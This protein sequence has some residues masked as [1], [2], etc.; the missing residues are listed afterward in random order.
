MPLVWNW[1]T[2]QM[3]KCRKTLPW[4][5]VRQWRISPTGVYVAEPSH[6]R[7][8]H[9][10]RQLY[11]PCFWVFFAIWNQKILSIQIS[12]I[13]TILLSPPLLIT[14]DNLFKNLRT[15]GVGATSK[16]TEG[17]S[18]EKELLWTSNVL[19]VSTPLGLLRAGF[20]YNGKCFCLRGGLL[21]ICQFPV[22]L[23]HPENLLHD[24]KHCVI[25]IMANIFF[26][27]HYLILSSLATF[28]I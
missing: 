10:L 23:K 14:V 25:C 5:H 16:Q 17:I 21:Q 8:R 6:T 27:V 4:V 22:I 11:I 7:A 13:R 15:S 28:F 24:C 20:F 19:N 3:W 26:G 9:I 18:K 2:C 1:R 12:W